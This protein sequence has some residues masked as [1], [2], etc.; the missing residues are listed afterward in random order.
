[1]KSLALNLASILVFILPFVAYFY[2]EHL[3][4]AILVVAGSMVLSFLVP[5]VGWRRPHPY[6]DDPNNVPYPRK[7]N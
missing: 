2:S 5:P 4:T 1:M 6:S 3:Q 7:S